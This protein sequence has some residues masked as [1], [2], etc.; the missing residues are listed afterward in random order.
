LDATLHLRILGPLE[1]ERDRQPI[2]LVG[3]RRRTLLAVL[4]VR[5]DEAVPAD[6]LIDAVWG[7]APP[8]TAAK[9]LQVH[10]SQLRKALGDDAIETR[11]HSYRLGRSVSVD[12]DHFETLVAAAA[13]QAP[14]TAAATLREALALWRGPPLADIG[15]ES[16]G[17][18]EIARLEELR[19]AALEARIDADLSLGRHAALVGEL[20]ALTERYPLHERFEAQLMVALYRSGRQVDALERY[21]RA[22]RTRIAQLGLEPGPEL[23]ALERAILRQDPQLGAGTRI[24]ERLRARRILPWVIAAACLTAVVAAVALTSDGHGRAS[25]NATV[26][27]H[28][29]VLAVDPHDGR[30]V[31]TIPVGTTPTAISVG[32]HA[33]WA[34]NADDQTVVRIDP[35]SRSDVK[36][37]GAGIPWTPVELAAGGGALWIASGGPGTSSAAVPGREPVA[38]APRGARPPARRRPGCGRA[39]RQ[40]RRALRRGAARGGAALPA[41]P[42]PRASRR[43]APAAE[44]RLRGAGH[45]GPARGDRALRR[46]PLLGRP[47]AARDARSPRHPRELRVRRERRHHGPR[48]DDRAHHRPRPGRCVAEHVGR[49]VRPRHRPALSDVAVSPAR[50]RVITGCVRPRTPV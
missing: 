50:H 4:V 16:F 12:A 35:R 26:P 39:L 25:A 15:D 38:L 8:A 37:F 5:H 7:E 40:S 31:A 14:A 23:Q 33:V 48:R 41:P 18:S 46:D 13:S 43:G 1:A 36:S 9:A 22:R 24:P 11:D 21:Q 32:E 44:R 30:I 42:P 27:D 3:T 29:S 20:Q 19:A 2:P 47:R 28:D 49:R 6:E 10:V 34:L 45:G 17:R